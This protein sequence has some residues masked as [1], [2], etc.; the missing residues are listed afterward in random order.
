M[1][2]HRAIYKQLIPTL[3]F[4]HKKRRFL[5]FIYRNKMI[6]SLEFSFKEHP[7]IPI[8]FFMI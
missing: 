2:G 3:A 5:I 8:I 1:L 6:M 7:L 4:I